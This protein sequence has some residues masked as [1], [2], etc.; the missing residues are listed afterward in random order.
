MLEPSRDRLCLRLSSSGS[1]QL[2]SVISYI[3]EERESYIC[4]Y[5]PHLVL[6]LARLEVSIVENRTWKEQPLRSVGVSCP[7]VILAKEQTSPVIVEKLV[8]MSTGLHASG[9]IQRNG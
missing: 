3:G 4:Q 8:F 7:F 6:H 1:P 9:Q 2:V 5:L